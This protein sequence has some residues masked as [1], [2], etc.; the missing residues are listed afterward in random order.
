MKFSR[1]K[2]AKRIAAVL[3]KGKYAREGSLSVVYLPSGEPACAVCVGKKFGKSVQR[4]RIKRLL[5]EAFR[6][7]SDE[8]SVSCEI[9]LIP[10]VSAEYSYAAF[11]RDLFKML[12]REKLIGNRAEGSVFE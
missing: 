5:R 11:R 8:I 6:S 3:K 10:R 2:K 7:V 4:N 1:L 12:K 9:L